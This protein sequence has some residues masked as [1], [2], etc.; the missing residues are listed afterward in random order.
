[1]YFENVEKFNLKNNLSNSDFIF[2][3]K[4]EQGNETLEN[5]MELCLEYFYKIVQ[6]KNLDQVFKNLEQELLG[7]QD[8]EGRKLFKEILLNTIY[9]HDLGK[10]NCNFQYKKLNNPALNNK[11]GLKFNNSNHSLLSSLIFMNYFYKKIRDN[12]SLSSNIRNKLIGFMVI[13]SYIISKHHTGLDSFQDFK[14]K[15]TNIDGEGRRLYNEEMAMFNKIYKEEIEFTEK[16]NLMKK[17][18]N[19]A[20]KQM[21]SRDETNDDKQIYRFIYTRLMLSLLI[22]CDFY[23]TGDFMKG[24][25]VSNFG[26]IKEIHK[27]YDVFKATEVCKG[28][29]SYE[30]NSYGSLKELDK[31]KDINI[32]RNEMFLDADAKLTE[33]INKSI[34]YLE[35]PTGSGKSNVA[36]NLS[37]KLIEEDKLINKI[38]YVYP[39]NTLVEQNIKS[40]EKIFEQREEIMKDIAVINSVVPIKERNIEEGDEWKKLD[41]DKSLLDRQFLNYPV[42]LTTHVSI[43]NYLFGT[44]KDNLFPLF[45]MANSVVVLDEIQSYKNSIWK[46]IIM[47]LNL[48]SKTLNMKFI[49]MS[50]TLPNFNKLIEDEKIAIK[51]IDNR[52]KYFKH[53]IFKDRVGLDFSLLDEEVNLEDL[54][55]HVTTTGKNNDKNILIEFIKK[56]TATT[57]YNYLNDYYGET[58]ESGKSEREILLITGD[59]NSIDRNK[60]IDKVKNEKKH[61]ISSYSSY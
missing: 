15:F 6:A 39:F 16:N 34:F 13:N 19:L 1:M 47:F 12:K 5:H 4:N 40:L 49:I 58:S 50:A 7:E 55:N 59:D 43:F 45:Q 28:I 27:F 36:L 23:S 11:E 41:Y 29:R 61:N 30:K 2:A 48:Y 46:E 31:V 53:P 60:I 32:L 42:V 57:F 35:A 8:I 26:E 51:L 25:K 3:H 22:A 52:D 54:R 56:E 24:C 37:F 33:N 9:M 20:E 18:L 14:N 21:F 17:M 38:F 44:S 10:I